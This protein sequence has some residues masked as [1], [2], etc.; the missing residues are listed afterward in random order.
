MSIYVYTYIYSIYFYNAHVHK[1]RFIFTLVNSPVNVFLFSPIV[2][3]Y[4]IKISYL[5]IYI[6]KG[7]KK[8]NIED[9][10]H[11]STFTKKCTNFQVLYLSCIVGS[12]STHTVYADH[13]M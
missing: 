7:I 3:K 2:T 1:K 12:W 11:S 8:M 4:P 10:S 5:Y 6:C 9:G 13:F